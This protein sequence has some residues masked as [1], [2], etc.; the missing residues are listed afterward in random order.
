MMKMATM[1]RENL[2]WEKEDKY[3]ALYPPRGI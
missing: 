1:H 2:N 3:G